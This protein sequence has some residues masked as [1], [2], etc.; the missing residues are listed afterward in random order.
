M[1]EAGYVELPVIQWLSGHG[2]TT[3]N[4]KGL[5]WTYRTEDEMTAFERPLS[6]PLVEKLLVAAII[7]INEVVKTEAQALEAV[8]ALRQTM[9]HHDK[10]T[11]NR[12]T[13]DRLRD[14]VRVVLNPGE[15][16]RTVFLIEFDPAKAHLN[17][18]T[19]TNQYRVQGVKQ[20]REDTVLLVNGIPLV[21]AEYKSYIASG[22]DWTEG[23][24]QLHRYQRQAPLMLTPNVFCVAADVRS[25]LE[26][27]PIISLAELLD[28]TAQSATRDEIYTMIVQTAL[29]VDWDAHPFVEPEGVRIFASAETAANFAKAAAKNPSPTGIFRVTV[30]ERFTWDG[31][32]WSVANVGENLV[33][34]RGEGKD[35]TELPIDTFHD[36]CRDGRILKSESTGGLHEHPEVAER[37]RTAG[38]EEIAEANRRF[39]K[40]APYIDRGR[41]DKG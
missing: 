36:L 30:G 8:R 9:D 15:D 26:R 34:L 10:L 3:P 21:I 13:L 28:E 11:A 27:R 16:A 38:P 19:A 2:S 25:C 12:E 7:R 6:D 40:I 18:Y 37:T 1:S 35:F 20:C 29:H 31:Q 33:S 17:D 22:H 5:G 24:H 39:R 23:V 32:P 4:D 14:G 41:R